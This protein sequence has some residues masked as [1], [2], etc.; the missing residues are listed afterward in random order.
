MIVELAQLT[1]V[2]GREAAFEAVFPTAIA[3]LA[4]SKGYL[5]HELRRS[6]ETPNR[7][8]LR[9]EWATLEDHTI[10]FRGSPAFTQWRAYVGPFF[11]APPAVEHFQPVAGEEI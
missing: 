11:G 8:A 3:V 10:G 5:A 7:Y 6:V 4:A 9:V 2:P 1:I